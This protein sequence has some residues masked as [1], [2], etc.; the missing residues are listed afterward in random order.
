MNLDILKKYEINT[1]K[2]RAAFMAQ[3]HHESQ[4]FTRKVENLNYSAKG[5]MN[6]WPAR[7]NTQA[8]ADAYARQ[9]EKIANKV[10]SDRMG[11]GDAASGEGWKYRGRGLL[12]ITG[13]DSYQAFAR[14]KGIELDEAVKYLETDEGALESACWYWQTRGLNGL[15]DTGDIRGITKRINGGTIGYAERKELY[16][17][18]LKKGV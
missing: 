13:K 12:Q 11:N 16:N 14:V 15:A 2:R 10:Y 1:L 17:E 9:P 8:L 5:L 6:T 3:C 7:F 18:Y 4:G